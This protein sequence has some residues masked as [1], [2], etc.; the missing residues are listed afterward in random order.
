MRS[1]RLWALLWFAVGLTHMACVGE[2]SDEVAMLAAL[3]PRGALACGASYLEVTE[4]SMNLVADLGT[5]GA[6]T[7]IVYEMNIPFAAGP[8]L[9]T[10]QVVFTLPAAFGFNGFN[11]LGS[12]EIGTWEFDFAPPFGTFNPGTVGYTIPHYPIDANTAYAD[13][14]KNGSY[15]AGVDPTAT[16]SLGVGGAHVFTLDLPLGGANQ[17]G[18]C[19]YFDTDVR[20]TLIDGI[21]ELPAVAG[22]YDASILAT[23]VDPDTGDADNHAG[24][25]PTTYQRTVPVTVPEP[26]AELSAIAA[27]AALAVVRA[28][29][30]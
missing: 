1:L 9:K 11:A 25:A 19:S 2:R 18:N 17:G 16:H 20:Y 7:G 12:S 5:P 29:R 28:R 22:T 23:S 27:A 30:V 14:K 4:S 21:L 13:A 3:S 10:R 6:T 8:L 15:D 26:G 24:V